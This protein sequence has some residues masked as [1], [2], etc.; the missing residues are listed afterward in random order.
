MTPTRR[1]FLTL[2][3]AA[4]TLSVSPVAFAQGNYPVRPVRVIVPFPPGGGTDILARLVAQNL[5]ERLGQPFDVENI[6][7]AGGSTGTGV[8]AKA[9]PDGYTMLF[10]FGSFVVN[11]SLFAKVPYDP[12]KDFQPVTL[13]ASTTT[14]LIVNPSVPSKT[15]GELVELTRASSGKYSF[16]SGGFGTQAHLTGEQLRLAGNIDLAHVP[17]GG[18]GPAVASV[19]EGNTPI[20][21]TSL[22]AGLPHI[23]S[24]KLRALAVTSKTRS[25]ELPDVPTMAEAGYPAIV[26]DSWVGV[27]VPNGTPDDITMLLH[28]TI[29]EFIGHP[30]MK[31]RLAK[32]GYEPIASTPEQFAERIKTEIASW[33]EVIA[34]AQIQVN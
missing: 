8:A 32:L 5:G 1:Q 18:A 21:F 23:R 9:A 33:A 19:V 12:F 7:G 24:G 31:A 22:A 34:A 25:S 2:T 17:F 20:G 16:A 30:D 29:T 28:R 3:A 27:L 26:G 6:E 10:V 15:V 14:V 13:A 11:P 4:L